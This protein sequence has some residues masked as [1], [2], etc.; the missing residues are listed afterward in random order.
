MATQRINQVEKL[1]HST[2]ECDIGPE[3]LFRPGQ[4]S[5]RY[6]IETESGVVWTEL[7]FTGAVALR[8]T[9]DVAATEDLV[10][11]YSRVCEVELSTWLDHLRAGEADHGLAEHLRHFIIYFDHFGA[12]EIVAS[13]YQVSASL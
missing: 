1:S 9:P 13:D 8:V 4:V 7:R 10:S 3:I 2:G 5:I 6:D 12:V 11:A